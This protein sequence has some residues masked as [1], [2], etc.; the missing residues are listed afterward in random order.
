M[1]DR[2][3]FHL[4][5][6][7]ANYV[8]VRI[9]GPLVSGWVPVL[10]RLRAGSFLASYPAL[11]QPEDFVRLLDGVRRLSRSIAGTAE[12]LP[13]DG[14]LVLA[15][16]GDTRGALRVTGEAS[17]ANGDN[18]LAFS[19]EE[20]DQTYLGPLLRDLEHAAEYLN[21]TG[22]ADDRHLPGTGHD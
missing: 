6:V 20:L 11:L 7:D 10:V 21:G 17:D 1:E 8:D 15:L 12:M 9:T 2:P 22:A 19:L 3:G 14:Q 4:G 18:R 13:T 5:G 16:E